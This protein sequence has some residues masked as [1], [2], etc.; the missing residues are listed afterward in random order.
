MPHLDPDNTDRANWAQDAVDVF[1]TATFGG[2]TFT[3]TLPEQPDVGD[4]PYCMVQDLITDLLHLANR[5]GW[6]TDDLIRRATGAYEEEFA[7]ES[8]NNLAP[9]DG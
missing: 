2:R 3:D 5:Q 7:E 4:D 9:A 1:G 8:E 6:D